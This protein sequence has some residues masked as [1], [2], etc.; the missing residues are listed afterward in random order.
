MISWS[1]ALRRM[2]MLLCAMFSGALWSVS[3]GS[4]E[5]LG[6]AA[7]ADGTTTFTDREPQTLV[8]RDRLAQLHRDR[9]VVAGHHHLGALRQ[10]DRPGDVGRPEEE[11]WPVVVEERLVTTTLAGLQHVHLALEVR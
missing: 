6:D 8:H 5:D 9:E 7:G 11:L 10:L 4:L 2:R 1:N 3:V